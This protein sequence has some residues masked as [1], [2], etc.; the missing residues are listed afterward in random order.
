MIITR[1]A[2]SDSGARES[3]KSAYISIELDYIV[4]FIHYE[5]IFTRIIDY[6]AATNDKNDVRQV[7]SHL[8][9][10]FRMLPKL[11]LDKLVYI[12]NDKYKY[13]ALFIKE[14]FKED[15]NLINNKCE[16]LKFLENSK[17]G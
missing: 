9:I 5:W 11:I 12:L 15:N 17:K 13:E 16:F 10:N 14:K 2:D 1:H 7:I 8:A 3:A 4:T 6:L